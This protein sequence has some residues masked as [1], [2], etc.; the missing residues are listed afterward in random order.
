M[1]KRLSKADQKFNIFLYFSSLFRSKKTGLHDK[2]DK[3]KEPKTKSVHT[4]SKSTHE[5]LLKQK[6]IVTLKVLN[7]N[8]IF[9]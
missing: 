3:V 2:N 5:V 6:I 7:L 4:V 1:M 8:V 9:A